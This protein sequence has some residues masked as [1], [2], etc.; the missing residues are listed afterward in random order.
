MVLI[1]LKKKDEWKEEK[2]RA[3]DINN[4]RI[5]NRTNVT[6]LEITNTKSF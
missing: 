1:I 3:R 6:Y 5:K 2:E 4:K